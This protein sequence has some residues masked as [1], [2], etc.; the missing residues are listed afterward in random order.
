MFNGSTYHVELWAKLAPGF[1]DTQLR[2]S[3]DR[4]LELLNRTF[5]TVVGTPL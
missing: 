1:A 5:A 4:Q 3:L 2:V